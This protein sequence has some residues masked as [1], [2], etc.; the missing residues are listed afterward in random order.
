M[1]LPLFYLQQIVLLGS[2]AFLAW[3]AVLSLRFGHFVWA[4][5]APQAWL[6]ALFLV[7]CF[8]LLIA[9]PLQLIA[10]KLPWRSAP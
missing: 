6:F 2:V 1:K 7:A 3:V 4:A 8:L 10:H 9:T 5:D